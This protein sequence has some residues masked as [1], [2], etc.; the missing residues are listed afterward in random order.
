MSKRACIAGSGREGKRQ[1][2]ELG[3]D[4][5]DCPICGIAMLHEILQ[6]QNGHSICKDCLKQLPPAHLKCPF[7]QAPYPKVPIRNF[8]LEGL[9]RECRFACASPVSFLGPSQDHGDS[10]DSVMDGLDGPMA[11]S[12]VDVGGIGDPEFARACLQAG[13]DPVDLNQPHDVEEELHT[14][15]E[16]GGSEGCGEPP[17][18]DPATIQPVVPPAPVEAEPARDPSDEILPHVP[19]AQPRAAAAE[20]Q[21]VVNGKMFTILRVGGKVSG[22]SYECPSCRIRKDLH[23]KNSG[24]TDDEGRRRLLAWAEACVPNHRKIGG[25]LLNQF[26]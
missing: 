15:F 22:L 18:P 13:C 8:S 17:P 21:I 26:A 16:K 2:F 19:P 14:I 4:A 7:C 25:R 6:C 3:A 12:D 23:Y 24:M 10:S 20:N 1:R 9:V 5:F 11:E